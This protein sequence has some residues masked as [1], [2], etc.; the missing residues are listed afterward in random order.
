VAPRSVDG[1]WQRWAACPGPESALF[2]PSAAAEPR[3][4]RELR[5]RRAKAIWARFPV[6]AP[7]LTYALETRELHGIWGGHSETE[8]QALLARRAG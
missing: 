7:C 6:R 4:A 1:A 8:R 5:E 3:P 2:Y